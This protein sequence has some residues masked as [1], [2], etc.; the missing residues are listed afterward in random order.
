MRRVTLAVAFLI[1]GAAPAFAGE[2][3]GTGQPAQGAIHGRSICAFSGLNDEPSGVPPGQTQNYGHSMQF[4]G[5]IP[6]LFN[7]GDACNPNLPPPPPPPG[8]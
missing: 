7:P 5:F 3:T 4:F 1:A 2:V 6:Q 8:V